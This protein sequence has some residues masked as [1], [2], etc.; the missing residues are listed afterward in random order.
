[1]CRKAKRSRSKRPC[2]R[3]NSGVKYSISPMLPSRTIIQ[4]IRP[5]LLILGLAVFCLIVGLYFLKRP[6]QGE[7]S[8]PISSKIGAGATAQ[9]SEPPAPTLHV[10]SIVQHGRIVEI[11]GNTDPGAIV[12]INGQPAATIFDGN[13]FRHFVGPLP[14][15]TSIVSI[16]SQNDHGG[17][18]TQQMAVTV[19]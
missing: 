11:Q 5:W 15:G 10:T 18:N 12:M 6:L 9:T 14:G 13:Q 19:E 2:R 16:T 8:H 3:N 17:V 7:Q 4:G 1:M